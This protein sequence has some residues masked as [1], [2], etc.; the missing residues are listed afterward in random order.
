M[1]ENKIQNIFGLFMFIT[2][3]KTWFYVFLIVGGLGLLVG[4][5]LFGFCMRKGIMKMEEGGNDDDYVNVS[6]G[7]GIDEKS[8]GTFDSVKDVPGKAQG[9][10]GNKP[11]KQTDS[12][13]DP[14]EKLGE[15]KMKTSL[16]SD[17]I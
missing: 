9:K 5:L 14:G 2:N 6:H 12:T 1:D 3:N 11:I 7:S 8:L 17:M 16:G 13:C 4:G 10:F 15:S